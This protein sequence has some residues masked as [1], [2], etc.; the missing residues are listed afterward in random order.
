MLQAPVR[1]APPGTNRKHGGIGIEDGLKLPG[2]GLTIPV[3]V[4][5]DDGIVLF[6]FDDR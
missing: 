5:T 4:F 6:A 2:I 1:W 3:H